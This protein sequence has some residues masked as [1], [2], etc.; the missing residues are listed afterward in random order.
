VCQPAFPM[1]LN[2]R[3]LLRTSAR[4]FKG[5]PQ[6]DLHSLKSPNGT[7]ALAVQKV[8]GPQSSTLDVPSGPVCDNKR[9]GIAGPMIDPARRE[10]HPCTNPPSAYR[11]ESLM[12]EVVAVSQSLLH[13]R[14]LIIYGKQPGCTGLMVVNRLTWSYICTALMS[15]RPYEVPVTNQSR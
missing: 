12:D 2:S 15:T 11:R 10:I 13:S 1:C 3:P 5:F 6:P 8:T 4:A 14:K 7:R 9:A